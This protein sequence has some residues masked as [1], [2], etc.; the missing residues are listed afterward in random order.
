MAENYPL[1][2]RGEHWKSAAV[3]PMFRAHPLAFDPGFPEDARLNAGAR[4]AWKC[5]YG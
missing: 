2:I 4:R 1:M 3:L 5:R